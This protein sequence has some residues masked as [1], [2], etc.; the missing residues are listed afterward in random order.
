MKIWE[1]M[2]EREKKKRSEGVNSDNW[3]EKKKKGYLE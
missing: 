1:R 3:K 2:S